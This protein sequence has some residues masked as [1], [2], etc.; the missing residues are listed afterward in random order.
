MNAVK[1]E[2]VFVSLYD[3]T[4]GCNSF[5]ILNPNEKCCFPQNH[6]LKLNTFFQT[7][8]KIICYYSDWQTQISENAVLFV[9][10]SDG[11]SW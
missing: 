11:I 6:R 7:F 2:E 8:I 5:E 3:C 1:E 4:T 10:C 9:T